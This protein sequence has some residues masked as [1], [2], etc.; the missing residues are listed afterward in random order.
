MAVAEMS[1]TVAHPV[2]RPSK[3]VDDGG[4]AATYVQVAAIAPLDPR[5]ATVI[6]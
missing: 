6:L 1:I 2:S 5:G 3:I 4:F